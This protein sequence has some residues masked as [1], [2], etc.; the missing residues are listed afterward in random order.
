MKSREDL[1]K[2]L[3]ILAMAPLFLGSMSASAALVDVYYEGT[4]GSI[5]GDG[6]GYSVSD[7]VSGTLVI[8]TDLAPADRYSSYANIGYYLQTSSTPND[9]VS[10]HLTADEGLYDQ[11]Y[12]EDDYSSTRDYFS[13][14][15]RD[16]SYTNLGQG[17]T[18]RTDN[19]LQLW[20]YDY[21]VDFI[22][23]SGLNQSFDLSSADVQQ[24]SGRIVNRSYSRGI[25]NSRNNEY[26]GANFSLSRL[27]YDLASVPEPGTMALIGLGLLGLGARRVLPKLTF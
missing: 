21:T 23:G 3:K 20:A 8:D 25:G 19:Y 13:I 11:V 16:Y 14:L 22:N 6:A 7:T 27:T 10:G 9:F 24:M 2:G 26:H 15:D 18:T 5:M 4:V 12:I 17:G 1:I